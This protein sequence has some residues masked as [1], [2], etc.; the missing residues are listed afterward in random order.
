MSKPM[1]PDQLLAALR[2]WKVPFREY[3]GWRTRG[4]PGAFTDVHGIVVHHTGSDSQSDDYLDF[5]FKRGRAEEGIPG[6]LCQV[7]TDMDGDL[8]LGAAGRANHAGRGSSATLTK[9]QTETYPGFTSELRA[10]PD[11]I[12]GNAAYYGNEVRYDGGQA[13][14]P[15]ARRTA[16]LHAAAV[17]DFHGWSALSAIG[18]REHSL[19]K[20]DPG[21]ERMDKF[22]ADLAAILKAGPGGTALNPELPGRD[23]TIKTW[24]VRYGTTTPKGLSGEAW[25]DC[26]QLV[27]FAAHPDIAAIT[28]HQRQGWLDAT[29][30]DSNWA[31][32]NALLTATVKLLQAKYRLPINGLL[33]ARLAALLRGYG[34]TIINN[35]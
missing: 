3:P 30:R 22:R 26:A 9:V 15:L 1:T 17:C 8:W 29:Q 18:H 4:R 35:G 16:L 5:L 19:R 27:A 7:S 20:N 10:G 34:Y 21:R 28:P 12:D 13:M 33:D 32:G 14:T 11:N 2:K 6:P 23:V 24:S 25:M 31:Y